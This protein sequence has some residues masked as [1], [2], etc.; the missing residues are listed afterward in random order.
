MSGMIDSAGIKHIRA[1]TSLYSSVE[2]YLKLS[3][4]KLFP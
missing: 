1:A 4:L 2:R 3:L